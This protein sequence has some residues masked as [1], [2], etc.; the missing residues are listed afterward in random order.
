MDI[1]VGARISVPVALVLCIIGAADG[2][3]AAAAP[4]ADHVLLAPHRAIYDLKLSKSRGSRGIEGVRGRI[5][6]DF[7]GSACEG[8]QLQFRQVSELDSGEGKAA[9]SDLRST[10]WEDGEGKKFRF[11]SENLFNERRTDIVDGHAERNAKAVAVSL[12]KPKEKSFAVPSNAVF[13]TE[14]MRRIIAA[15][16]EGKSVLDFPVYDGSESGE[17]LYNTLTVIGHA[18]ASDEKVPTD[19]SA[20]IPALAKLV[21][22]PVTVSY[23]DKKD[24]KAEQSGEQTPV[25]SITFELYENGISR[26]LILDYTDFTISGEMTS[27]ELKNAKPCP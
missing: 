2:Q 20:K 5:L 11:N 26:S 7:S 22:W 16:R 21:R 10:T 3:R 8:Y 18:I 13:P 6:Y 17:K 9:L 19:A 23:F 25:Y 15:A 14:H 27:L 24:E 1:F 12:S 4:P